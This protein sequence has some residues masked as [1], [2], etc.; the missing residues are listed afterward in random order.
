MRFEILPFERI[1]KT[2]IELLHEIDD[3]RAEKFQG[4][5]VEPI[6]RYLADSQLDHSGVVSLQ[7]PL[8]WLIFQQFGLFLIKQLVASV[9]AEHLVYGFDELGVYVLFLALQ[10]VQVGLQCFQVGVLG[11]WHIV[12][13]SP[14]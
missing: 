8:I 3:M 13:G 12:H 7:G 10:D 6:E 14:A 4:R 2:G 5:C 1:V 9:L 11:I